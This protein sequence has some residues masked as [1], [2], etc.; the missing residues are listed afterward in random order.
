MPFAASTN[1]TSLDSSMAAAI[2]R[3]SGEMPTPS[4]DSPSPMAPAWARLSRSITTSRLLG[5]SLTQ[6]RRPSGATTVPRGLVP[7]AISA[8]TLSVCVSITLSVP[9][10]SLGT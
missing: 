8:T 2:Q 7:A 6:A 5:W 4:G 1:T 10:P 3:P 9:E